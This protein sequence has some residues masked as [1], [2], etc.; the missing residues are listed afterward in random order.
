[1]WA[2]A[3]ACAERE[4]AQ[5]RTYALTVEKVMSKVLKNDQELGIRIERVLRESRNNLVKGTWVNFT[6]IYGGLSRKNSVQSMEQ[7]KDNA[8]RRELSMSGFNNY[9]CF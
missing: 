2:T 6:E 7:M 1:M 4:T 9:I 5:T 8:A 3:E